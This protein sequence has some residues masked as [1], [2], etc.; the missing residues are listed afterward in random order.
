MAQIREPLL[1]NLG[2]AVEAI[3]KGT[4]QQMAKASRMSAE[5]TI[6]WIVDRIC[7]QTLDRHPGDTEFVYEQADIFVNALFGQPNVSLKV[8]QCINDMKAEAT[9]TR[10]Q[11]EQ[12]A[13]LRDMELRKAGGQQTKNVQNLFGSNSVKGEGNMNVGGGSISM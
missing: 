13:H 7:R 1:S 5:N 6:L 8:M 10:Q 12:V 4:I 9:K 2:Q 11:M 3:C